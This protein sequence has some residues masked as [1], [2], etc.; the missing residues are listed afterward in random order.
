MTLITMIDYC[1]M[2]LIMVIVVIFQPLHLLPL[3]FS[4]E[5]DPL[6]TVANNDPPHIVDDDPRYLMYVSTQ[7]L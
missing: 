6:H 1:Q 3:L 5:G 4:S 2:T 7:N